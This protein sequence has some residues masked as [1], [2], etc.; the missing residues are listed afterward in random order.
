M[1]EIPRFQVGVP[2]APLGHLFDHPACSLLE[3]GRSRQAGT[4]SV[5][6]HMQGLHGLRMLHFLGLDAAVG[7]II[8]TN[9]S[10]Q[11]TPDKQQ[12]EQLL[13]HV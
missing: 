10:G 13:V 2:E 3:I 9:L 11:K 12:G 8:D 1:T 4:I 6:E 7:G 5:G